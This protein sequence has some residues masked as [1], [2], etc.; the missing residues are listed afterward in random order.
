[1]LLI[2]CCLFLFLF[3]QSLGSFEPYIYII[4]DGRKNS[5]FLGVK[6]KPFNIFLKIAACLTTGRHKIKLTI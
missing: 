6:S 1:M 4:Q 2:V 5:K 3:T